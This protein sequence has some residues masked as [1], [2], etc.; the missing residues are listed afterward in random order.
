MTSALESPGP[1]PRIGE[2]IRVNAELAAEFRKLEL[3]PDVAPRSGPL[4]AS[5]RLASLVADR[6]SLA[7]RLDAADAELDSIKAEWDRLVSHN[8][9]LAAEVRRLRGGGLGLARRAWARLLL[10]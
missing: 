2:L 7:A 4:P 5:R 1:D 3:S 6:D 8:R 9:E 10:H